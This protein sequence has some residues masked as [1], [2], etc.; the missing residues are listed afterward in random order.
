MK[1]I[2]CVL[3]MLSL[4]LLSGC[5][6]NTT[7]APKDDVTNNTTSKT[8]A[9]ELDIQIGQTNKLKYKNTVSYANWTNDDAIIDNAINQTE[10]LVSSVL[11]LPIYKMDSM[12]N[13]EQFIDDFEEILT[14]DNGYNEVPSFL[15]V[16]SEYDAEFFENNTLFV[17]YVSST[18]G[19]ERFDVKNV[20]IENSRLRV[21]VE[22]T[23]N[24]EIVTEDMSGWFMIV[25]IKDE[26]I[27]DCEYFD[28]VF[29]MI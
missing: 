8:S 19:S 1:I 9:D 29:G 13:L 17:V 11:H 3:I 24:P 12:E 23:N 10:L 22:Q 21:H 6:R 26:Y 2:K 25:E 7:R 18:T 14:L 28:A 5:V 15:E 4:T 20:I 16:T 27:A